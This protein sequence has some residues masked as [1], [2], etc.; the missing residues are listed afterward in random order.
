M[1][2]RHVDLGPLLSLL[3]ALGIGHVFQHF[4]LT[5]TAG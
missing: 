5:F 3:C 2:D 4:V 1:S